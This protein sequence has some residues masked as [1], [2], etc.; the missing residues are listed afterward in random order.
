[1][2][3]LVFTRFVWVAR[4]RLPGRAMRHVRSCL[5]KFLLV[6]IE[7]GCP[8]WSLA[9][10]NCSPSRRS[11]RAL[12]CAEPKRLPSK[13]GMGFEA[14][15]DRPVELSSRASAPKTSGQAITRDASN[16]ISEIGSCGAL[17]FHSCCVLFLLSALRLCELVNG[18]TGR[19]VLNWLSA[20][21]QRCCVRSVTR[22]PRYVAH[23]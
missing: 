9:R 8:T 5:V 15:K 20:T 14:R 1:M 2:T 10:P 12:F 19:R 18:G 23:C 6:Y 11:S 3:A 7:P 22:A 13:D 16:V 4:P 17:A 21:G